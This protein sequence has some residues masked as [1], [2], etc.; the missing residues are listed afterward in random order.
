MIKDFNGFIDPLADLSFLALANIKTYT[1]FFVTGAHRGDAR[2]IA[3]DHYGSIDYDRVVLYYN[4]LLCEYEIVEGMTLRLPNK[5]AVDT[6][7]KISKGIRTV[8]I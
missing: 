8:K 5:V 7:T 4:G 2:L 1:E 3:F 6:K